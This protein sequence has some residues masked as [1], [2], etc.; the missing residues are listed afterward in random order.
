VDSEIALHFII[1]S[2]RGK[3]PKKEWAGHVQI[4][5]FKSCF[6]LTMPHTGISFPQEALCSRQMSNHREE[7]TQ[8]R[9]HRQ[10]VSD[11]ERGR[12]KATN[13]R[14]TGGFSRFYFCRAR[15]AACAIEYLEDK[16]SRVETRR[17]SIRRRGED[18]K[19]WWRGAAVA[20]HAY[21]QAA[22]LPCFISWL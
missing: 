17:P 3:V 15:L 9:R 7:Q 13:K 1:L 10:C 14:V 18:E 19:G 6:N 5:T 16:S 8:L 21:H 22:T 20:L 2:H 11:R 4:W 12:F